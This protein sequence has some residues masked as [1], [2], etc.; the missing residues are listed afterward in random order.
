M[1]MGLAFFCSVGMNVGNF[2]FLQP[3]SK[4]IEK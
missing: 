3:N 1:I 2:V 4:S